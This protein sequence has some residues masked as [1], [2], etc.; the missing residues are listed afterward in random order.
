MHACNVGI[1]MMMTK[2]LNPPYLVCDELQEAGGKVSDVPDVLLAP[3]RVP[4]HQQEEDEKAD[5]MSPDVDCLVVKPED[6]PETILVLESLSVAPE[7]GDFLVVV[8]NLLN[9]E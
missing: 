4:D 9:L 3:K 1:M 8:R 7:D 5:E 2:D 6:A